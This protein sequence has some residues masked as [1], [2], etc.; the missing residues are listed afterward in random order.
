VSDF[1]T[2][3][4]IAKELIYHFKTGC[5]IIIQAHRVFASCEIFIE[6]EAYDASL[7]SVVSSRIAPLAVFSRCEVRKM[8][9]ISIPSCLISRQHFLLL[10][11]M[12]TLELQSPEQRLHF[13]RLKETQD[14]Q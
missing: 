11:N 3:T 7:P 4:S 5:K 2:R 12:P 14:L 6:D 10:T 13:E 1:L 8:Q 9:R